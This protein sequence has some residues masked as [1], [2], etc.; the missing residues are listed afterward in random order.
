MTAL[1][2]AKNTIELRRRF[3]KLFFVDANVTIFNYPEI[4]FLIK[5]TFI[6]S[7]CLVYYLYSLNKAIQEYLGLLV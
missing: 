4:K 1:N 2:V 6:R 7:K 5:F 3:S